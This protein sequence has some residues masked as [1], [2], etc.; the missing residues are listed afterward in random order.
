M[1]I[2]ILTLLIL[3]KKSLYMGIILVYKNYNIFRGLV[4]KPTQ[5]SIWRFS[6]QKQKILIWYNWQQWVVQLIYLFKEL[7]NNESVIYN[8]IINYYFFVLSDTCL[9]DSRLYN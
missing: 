4:A 5:D 7:H 1:P 3:L 9:Y 6:L 8:L 2:N